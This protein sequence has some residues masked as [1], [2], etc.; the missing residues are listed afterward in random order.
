[1]AGKALSAPGFPQQPKDNRPQRKPSSNNRATL[2]NVYEGL[3]PVPSNFWGAPVLLDANGVKYCPGYTGPTFSKNK[4]DY[5]QIEFPGGGLIGKTPGLCKVSV[6]RGRKVDRKKSSGS[7]GERLT[8]TGI[9]NADIEIAIEIWTP[10]QFDKLNDLWRLIQP[11]AGKG[12]PQA[13][14]IKHPQFE[15]NGIKSCVF[16]EARG[17]EPGSV[18]G[19]RV[20]VIQAIEYLPPG[21]KNVTNT[22]KRAQSRGSKLD[23]PEHQLSGKNPHATGPRR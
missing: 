18:V 19:M 8:F 13:F 23:G 21:N 12:Q 11:P 22:P 17:F 15:T 2:K 6:R 3:N 9:S 7:D 10:D 20:F 14:D 4:T 16:V 5:V 1:M